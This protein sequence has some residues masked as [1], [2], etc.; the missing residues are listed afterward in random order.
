[1]KTLHNIYLQGFYK[2]VIAGLVIQIV[3][4]ACIKYKIDVLEDIALLAILITT[5]RPLCIN[6]NFY[7]N[8][9]HIINRPFSKSE[10]LRFYFYIRSVKFVFFLTPILVYNSYFSKGASSFKSLNYMTTYNFILILFGL[11]YVFPILF[12]QKK[13]FHI[14]PKKLKNIKWSSWTLGWISGAVALFTVLWLSKSYETTSFILSIFILTSVF[15]NNFNNV[16]KLYPFKK[17]LTRG[18]VFSTI[19]ITPFIFLIFSLRNTVLKSDISPAKKIS[20][21]LNLA[22]FTP[23]LEKK[24]RLE[25]LRS[26]KIDYDYED[27]LDIGLHKKISLSNLLSTVDTKR[28]KGSLFRRLPP[29]KNKS[30]MILILRFE[31]RINPNNKY[32]VIRLPKIDYKSFKTSDGIRFVKELTQS[33]RYGDVMYAAI[34]LRKILPKQKANELISKIENPVF[35]QSQIFKRSVASIKD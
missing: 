2:K 13:Q 20:S 32:R 33:E 31:A 16:F 28:K 27:L 9:T 7:R 23:E 10:L 6:N 4:F 22:E 24:E 29:I 3:S 26:T 21:I 34:I 1:M 18:A 12:I 25:I 14:A 35:K 8:I 5:I 19:I 15:F 17:L 30:D 11:I